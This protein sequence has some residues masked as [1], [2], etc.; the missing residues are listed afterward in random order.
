MKLLTRCKEGGYTATQGW[1][2]ESKAP[3]DSVR[4]D[5]AIVESDSTE[6]LSF[7]PYRKR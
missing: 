3:V 6:T 4:A 1:F 5:D 7:Q 2:P